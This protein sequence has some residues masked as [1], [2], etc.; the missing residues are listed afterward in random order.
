[1][2]VAAIQLPKTTPSTQNSDDSPYFIIPPDNGI[3]LAFLSQCSQIDCILLECIKAFFSTFALDVPVTSNLLN[4]SPKYWLSKP[5]LLD[6]R[7]NRGV[8][9]KGKQKMILSKI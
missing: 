8:L 6:D 5:G 9:Y 1:M 4:S 3:D 7:C 2:G